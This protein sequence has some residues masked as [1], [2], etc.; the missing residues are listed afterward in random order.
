MDVIRA[1]S[2]F[3]RGKNAYKQNL[4]FEVCLKNLGVDWRSLLQ[5][6]LK[7]L[8]VDLTSFCR[9]KNA[10]PAVVD[11]VTGLRV[12]RTATTRTTT[13]QPHSASLS[14]KCKVLYTVIKY[15]LWSCRKWVKMLTVNQTWNESTTGRTN[16]QNQIIKPKTAYTSPAA[17]KW[18]IPNLWLQNRIS[19]TDDLEPCWLRAADQTKIVLEPRT[20]RKFMVNVRHEASTS[21]AR[22]SRTLS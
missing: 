22:S 2:T 14:Q 7:K 8:C 17:S 13:S 16:K 6:I 9:C 5:R 19:M 4:K 12:C 18:K 10:Q 20:G 15:K 1:C 3:G 21:S 11:T